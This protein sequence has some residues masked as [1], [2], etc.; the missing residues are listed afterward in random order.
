MTLWVEEAGI[1]PTEPLQLAIDTTDP[2]RIVLSGSFGKEASDVPS[3]RIER[4][5]LLG[6]RGR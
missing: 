3:G 5:V 4:T 1:D 6:S 2:V